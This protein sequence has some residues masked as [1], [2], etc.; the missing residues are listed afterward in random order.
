MASLTM[1]TNSS[2]KK[3]GIERV[4]VV[5]ARWMNNNNIIVIHVILKRDKTPWKTTVAL[6]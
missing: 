5:M 6:H 3:K 4:Q 1:R 2:T